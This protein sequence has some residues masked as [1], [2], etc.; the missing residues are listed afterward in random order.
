M[1]MMSKTRIL[2]GLLIVFCAIETGC[3]PSNAYQP[4]PP[5]KVTV[6]TPIR[7]DV[8]IYL[9]ETGTT[10]A[11]DLAEVRARVRGFLDDIKFEA[12]TDVEEGQVL[13]Q[14]EKTQYAA[15]V[16]AA[17]ADLAA[18]QV[19]LE[20]AQIEFNRQDSL[21]KQD[22][23][24]ETALVSARAARDEAKAAIEASQANLDQAQLN[25]SYTDVVAPITGRVGKTLVKQ[26]NLVDG[27]EATHLTTVIKYDP[28]Y[29]NFN[30]NESQLLTLMKTAQE[31]E[32]SGD[33]YKSKL[34]LRRQTDIGFPFEG[35]FEY[36]D[37]AVD[38]STGTFMIR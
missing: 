7:R 13:Y 10:E 28:I 21:F 26:G 24:A 34:Y 30:I 14:I 4:P 16:A 17:K 38:Q 32:N 23:T 20:K 8:T 2:V 5:A 37:L 35:Q 29:A 11:V 3:A 27:G 31:M 6:A 19:E 1:V 12:G 15:A 36:A 25:L 9:E 22:A 18:Q 33:K